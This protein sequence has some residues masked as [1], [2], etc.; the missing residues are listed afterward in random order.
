MQHS[1]TVDHGILL[2]R[3]KQYL[4]ITG[5]ELTWLHQ[6]LSNLMQTANVFGKPSFQGDL[7]HGVPQGSGAGPFWV[8]GLPLWGIITHHDSDT[9]YHLFADDNQ[10]FWIFWALPWFKLIVSKS[11]L[12]YTYH[13][14]EN[15]N[16]YKY[17]HYC[18]LLIS[19]LWDTIVYASLFQLPNVLCLLKFQWKLSL[20][21][22]QSP[23]EPD[24]SS[25]ITCLTFSLNYN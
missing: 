14:K 25:N 12:I 4:G 13:Y 23:Y 9:K 21:I 6:Y 19:Q 3:L 24:Y 5:N 1:T 2:H 11:N 20:S 16:T 7:Y 17:I 18:L 8:S 22:F 10:L 15:K